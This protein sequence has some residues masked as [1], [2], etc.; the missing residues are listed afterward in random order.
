MPMICENFLMQVIQLSVASDPLLTHN[1]HP[2]Y[3]L[4]TYNKG[5]FL[6]LCNSLKSLPLYLKE[7]SFSELTY[8]NFPS[9]KLIHS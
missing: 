3:V 1:I 2:W 7:C 4:S 6:K 5:H 9:Y 8:R